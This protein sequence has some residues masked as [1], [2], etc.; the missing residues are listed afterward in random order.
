MF[1]RSREPRRAPGGPGE[2]LR[3]ENVRRVYGA[4][5]NQVAALDGVSLSLPA[6]SFTAVMGPSGSGKSTLLQCAAG[7]DRPTEGRVFV[8]GAELTGDGE[9]ALTRFRRQ[10]IG[11]V[12]QQFNL[13]PT[14]TVMEN[15]VLPLKL[16]GRRPDRARAREILERVGLGQ[17]LGHLPAQLSGGQQQRVAIARALVTEPRVVFADEPTGALDT[18]SARDVLSLLRESVRTFGQ[19]VVMVTHDPVAASYANAV[20]YLA[21]GRIVGHQAAPTAEA[22]AERM[23]HLADEVER[24]RTMAGA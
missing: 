5:G 1:G 7:L 14:L 12:F 2:A 10:R 6:G 18:R 24:Q 17:R 3:L 23:T 8:D 13:L 15:T 21:D 22:V 4:E 16:A 20:L 19:T 9:A 11:F